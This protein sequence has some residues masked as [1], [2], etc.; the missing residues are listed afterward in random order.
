MISLLYIYGCFIGGLSGMIF[1][2]YY[3]T[4]NINY[5]NNSKYL[6]L[7]DFVK[8]NDYNNYVLQKV[9]FKISKYFPELS[10]E[11]KNKLLLA[12]SKINN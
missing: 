6:L 5:Y 12:L 9:K 10:R 8:H 7:Y 2:K 3:K 4:D 1:Y 11:E